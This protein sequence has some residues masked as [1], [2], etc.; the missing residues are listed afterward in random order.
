MRRAEALANSAFT[1]TNCDSG[2][3]KLFQGG[4]KQRCW[5][6]YESDTRTRSPTGVLPTQTVALATLKLK[7]ENDWPVS[8]L[9]YFKLGPHNAR[10]VRR[11]CRGN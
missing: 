1:N 3:R 5:E 11:S 8:F 6:A 4:K 7:W 2:D 9:F 10:I